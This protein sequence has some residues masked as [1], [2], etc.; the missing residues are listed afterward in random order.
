MAAFELPGYEVDGAVSDGGQTW[1][2]RRGADGRTV[3]LRLVVPPVEPAALDDVRRAMARVGGLA[4]DSLLSLH[5]VVTTDRGL[6]LVYD[7]PAGGP[8]TALLTARSR[9]TVGETVTLGTGLADALSVVHQAGLCHGQL[10]ESSVYLGLDGTPLLADVGL[11]HGRPT[12]D[13]RALAGLC[14]RALSGGRRMGLGPAAG[15]MAILTAMEKEPPGDAVD[16]S[17]ALRGAAPRVPIRLGAAASPAV[18]ESASTAE[19]PIDRGAGGR[20][21]QSAAEDGRLPS[22]GP[23]DNDAASVADVGGPSGRDLSVSRRSL[24]SRRPASGS[25]S[26]RPRRRGAA[27][28]VH[29]GRA[30]LRSRLGRRLLTGVAVVAG[31]LLAVMVG[32]QWARLGGSPTAV[33]LPARPATAPTSPTT[34]TATS[35]ATRSP[36]SPPPAPR[37][38]SSPATARPVSSWRA[39][40]GVLDQRRAAAFAAADPAALATVDAPSSPALRADRQLATELRQRGARARGLQWEISRAAVDSAGPPAVV[41]RVTDRMSAH[42]LVAANGAILHSQPAR[43]EARWRVTLLPGSGG[44]RIAEIAAA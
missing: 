19:L 39:I 33:T 18:A 3:L 27:V 16:L 42:D 37:P 1:R 41:L 13:L 25:A 10:G 14:R 12:E 26:K 31:L 6:V 40:L 34:A 43:G 15:L 9:L 35:A 38:P 32:V 22:A 4:A 2:A 5:T 24:R 30:P 44:W 20:E 8:L 17:A 11:I 29:R 7:Y 28:A 23:G 36:T 21:P